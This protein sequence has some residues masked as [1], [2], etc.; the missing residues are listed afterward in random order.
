ME[1][2]AVE[3]AAAL[4]VAELDRVEVDLA[5]QGRQLDRVGGVGDRRR[6]VE[7]LED[8]LHPGARLLPD[9]QEARE[10]PGRRDQLA[11]V[12]GEGEEGA[13]ADLPPQRQPAAEGEDRHL[14]EGG[15]RLQQR[16]EARGQPDRPHLRAVEVLGGGGDPLQLAPLL[17]E[18]LHH[19]HAVDRLVDDLDHLA[20]ALLGVPGGGEDLGPHPVADRE[21]GRRDDQADQGQRRREPQHHAQRQHHQQDVAAHHRDEH[22]EALDERRVA[23]GA[24]DELA[25]RHPVERGEVHLLEVRLHLVA[26]VV[27]DLERDLA[28]AVPAQVGGEEGARGDRDQSEQPGQQ[29]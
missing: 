5:A 11:D 4:V 21:Q 25:G 26:E 7:Q 3:D 8:P 15:D 12:G 9:R 22:Q 29:R 19:A 20:F 13:E 23:A 28:A 18:R 16:L 6:E 2:E 10:L 24:S 17:A 27:L 1:V 14:A